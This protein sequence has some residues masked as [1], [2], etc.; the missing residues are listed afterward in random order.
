MAWSASAFASASAAL[1]AES[2][3]VLAGLWR[4]SGETSAHLT[5]PA[6]SGLGATENGPRGGESVL[7]S[8]R[9]QWQ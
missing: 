3:E 9:G 4:G 1:A 6:G 5:G 8:T 7:M 2:P